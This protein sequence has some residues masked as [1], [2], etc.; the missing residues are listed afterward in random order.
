MLK[1]KA[2]SAGVEIVEV[3]PANTSRTCHTCGHASADNRVEEAFACLSCGHRAH[4]DT[5]AARN[6]LRLGL[7]RREA[8]A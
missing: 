1:Y 3:N 7:S 2:E 4:A 6:I 8:A 5:N